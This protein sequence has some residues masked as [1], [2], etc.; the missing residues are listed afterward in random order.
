MVNSLNSSFIVKVK[1]GF[2]HSLCLTDFAVASIFAFPACHNSSQL[3]HDF[4]QRYTLDGL[5]PSEVE[6]DGRKSTRK[7]RGERAMEEVDTMMA[8][9]VSSKGYSC[10]GGFRCLGPYLVIRFIPHG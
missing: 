10:L 6:K 3:Q 5:S 1:I 4:E 2:S 8:K 9:R 7:S